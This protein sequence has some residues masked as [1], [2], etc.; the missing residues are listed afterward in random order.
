MKNL[1]KLFILTQSL[2][3]FATGWGQVQPQEMT[4]GNNLMFSPPEVRQLEE[5]KSFRAPGVAP[6]MPATNY[7][8]GFPLNYYQ[9]YVLN[10]NIMMQMF[11]Q[12][13]Q[14][15]LLSMMAP[16]LA[17]SPTMAAYPTQDTPREVLP[18]KKQ[19]VNILE[20]PASDDLIETTIKSDSPS[21][22][23]S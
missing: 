11:L 20:P 7:T 8:Q 16:H 15:I 17:G 19:E 3:A 5:G 2:S 1:L 4:T 10:Q 23:E 12:N 21:I 22:K 14:Q 6:E 18:Q 13:Q 9:S